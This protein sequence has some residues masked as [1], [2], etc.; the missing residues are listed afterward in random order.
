[1][2]AVPKARLE[3]FADGIFA[4]AATLLTLNLAVNE[5][6]PLA[7]ELMRIWPGYAAYAI[8]FTTIGIIWMNHHLLLHQISHTDRFFLLLNVLFLM[9]IAFI[10]FPTRLLA[11]YINADGA[12]AAAFAYGITLTLTAILFNAIW[13]YA[14]WGRRLIRQDADARVVSGIGRSYLPGPFIYLAATLVALVSPQVSAGLYAAIAVFYV[15]ESS[16]FGRE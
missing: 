12:Q 4:I 13:R 14:A 6:S 5:H 8:S 9:L 7:G 11:L 2:D 15:L 16:V 3:A 1:M 10:P